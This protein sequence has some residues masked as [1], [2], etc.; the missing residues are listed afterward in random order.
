MEKPGRGFVDRE[1]AS[2]FLMILYGDQRRP[3]PVGTRTDPSSDE[4]TMQENQRDNLV[5]GR[6]C[7]EK[8]LQMIYQ[9]EFSTTEITLDD[10]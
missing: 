3:L 1:A 8:A 10:S 4:V 5:K 9:S 7:L 6:W 2:R